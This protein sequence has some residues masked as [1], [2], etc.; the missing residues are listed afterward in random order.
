MGIINVFS[1]EYLIVFVHIVQSLL[2]MYIYG[3]FFSLILTYRCLK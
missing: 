2:N 1:V 3:V